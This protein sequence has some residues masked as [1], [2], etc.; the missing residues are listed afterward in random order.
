MEES[1]LGYLPVLVASWMKRAGQ[2]RIATSFVGEVDIAVE[3]GTLVMVGETH[4][5][6]GNAPT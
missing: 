5:L 1:T 4:P 2:K 3:V 6:H